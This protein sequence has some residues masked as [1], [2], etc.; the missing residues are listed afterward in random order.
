MI[1]KPKGTHDILP[2]EIDTW[3]ALEEKFFG[4]CERFGYKEISQSWIF[5]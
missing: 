3:R 2:D 1:K 4:V 5:I